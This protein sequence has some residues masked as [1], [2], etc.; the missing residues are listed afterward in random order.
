MS[1]EDQFDHACEVCGE[2]F[3]SER[4]LSEHLYSIGLV[5]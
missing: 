3:Q 5:H 1:Q 4:A 2:E